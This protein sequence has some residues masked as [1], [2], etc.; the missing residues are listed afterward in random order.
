MIYKLHKNGSYNIHTIKTDRF[1]NIRMEIILRN[2]I[3]PK[4]VAKRTVLF[5]MLMENSELYQT[6][7]DL[8]LKQEELYNSTC[9]SITSKLGNEVITSICMDFLNPKYTKDNFLSE[10]IKLPFDLLFK[11]NIKDNE[12]DELTLETIKTRVKSDIMCL[13][14]NPSKLAILNSLKAMD[15]K[16]ISSVNLMGTIEEV[17]SITKSNLYDTYKDILTHD[18]ID[19]FVIGDFDENKIIDLINKYASFKTIKNHPLELYVDNETRSKK[20]IVKEKSNFAQS[21]LVYI[22]NTINLTAEEKKY[23]MQIYNMILG[24]GSLE[25]KLYQNLRDKN[26]LCYNVNSIYNKYDN[27]IIINTAVDKKNINKTSKLIEKSIDEMFENVTEEE[28]S[29]AVSSIITSINM[30]LDQPGRIIDNYMFNYM[31][32]LDAIDERI[33]KYKEI[34]LEDVKRVA[35]KVKINT[36]YILEGEANGED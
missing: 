19:I 1:K 36:I 33:Q 24:G 34:T 10:A 5:D 29:R 16:S 4:N 12:F 20:N 2:N 32:E 26:S 25:T 13:N 8:V 11:P 6:K 17:D 23:A 30:S 7:R 21:Q 22:C 27:L 9:Y 28:I 18:Y 3:E 31:S 15:S 35:K 14:E